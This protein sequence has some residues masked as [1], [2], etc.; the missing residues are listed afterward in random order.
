MVS[1]YCSIS[2]NPTALYNRIARSDVDMVSKYIASKPTRF[3]S[4][5]AVDNN[6][7]PKPC[8]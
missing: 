2:S 4:S 7:Y 5:K 3:A 6:R 8:P 1:L